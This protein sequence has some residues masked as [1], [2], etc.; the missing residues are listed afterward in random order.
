MPDIDHLLLPIGGVEEGGVNTGLLLKL[1]IP[2]YRLIHHIAFLASSPTWAILSSAQPQFWR[3]GRQV[4]QFSK[5][6]SFL[7]LARGGRREGEGRSEGVKVGR[8]EV[9]WM[10]TTQPVVPIWGPARPHTCPRCGNVTAQR[11]CVLGGGRTCIRG[12]TE[13]LLGNVQILIYLMASWLDCLYHLKQIK[14]AFETSENIDWY[15]KGIT[16]ILH[17][18][19]TEIL[20]GS[21]YSIA[22]ELIFMESPEVVDALMYEPLLFIYVNNNY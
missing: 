13:I 4:K 1:L 11:A 22:P 18:Q 20:Q 16:K 19:H 17:L 5:L 8:E 7:L 6:G 14:S 10:T 3:I 21:V 2:L 15:R 12:R 9:A